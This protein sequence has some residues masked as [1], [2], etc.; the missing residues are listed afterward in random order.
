MHVGAGAGHGTK[1][2][3]AS[4]G[5]CDTLI[6]NLSYNKDLEVFEKALQL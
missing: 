2:N 3:G 6:F 4:S 1:Q 5:L